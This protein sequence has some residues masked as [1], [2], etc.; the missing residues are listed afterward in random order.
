MTG[1][2]QA[3]ELPLQCA[4]CPGTSLH[5]KGGCAILREPQ[6]PLWEEAVGIDFAQMPLGH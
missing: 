6:G 3:K 5:F 4:A 2:V 1:A